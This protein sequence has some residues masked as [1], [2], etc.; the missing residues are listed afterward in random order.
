MV[1]LINAPYPEHSFK[2]PFRYPQP[3][4]GTLLFYCK[5]R[6][7]KRLGGVGGSRNPSKENISQKNWGN[8]VSNPTGAT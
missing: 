2:T 6:D 1:K 8:V 5:K 7:D 4:A 3:F